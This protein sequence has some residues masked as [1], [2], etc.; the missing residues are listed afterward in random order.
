[1]WRIFPFAHADHV[2]VVFSFLAPLETVT[3][4]GRAWPH[5]SDDFIFVAYGASGA[6]L[7]ASVHDGQVCEG[8]SHPAGD[9]RVLHCKLFALETS[10]GF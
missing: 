3:H 2:K 9:E 4:L 8:F 5:L 10:Y 1:M 7:S 6:G